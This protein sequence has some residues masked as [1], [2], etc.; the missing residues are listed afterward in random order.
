MGCFF[1]YWG[2][3]IIRKIFNC[4]KNKNNIEFHFRDKFSHLHLINDSFSIFPKVK[5]YIVTLSYYI[6]NIKKFC[7]LE[8]LSWRLIHAQQGLHYWVTTSYCSL[9]NNFL[10]CFF[11]IVEMF[12]F[13]L[14]L[15]SLLCHFCHTCYVCFFIVM[16][17]IH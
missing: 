11:F 16:N 12:T 8:D 3:K 5:Y 14:L 7:I 10:L 6:F 15:Y 17:R 1:L 2:V 4:L 13:W 9:F